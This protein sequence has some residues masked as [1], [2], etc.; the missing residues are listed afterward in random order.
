MY[1][2]IVYIC[3]CNYWCVANSNNPF[4]MHDVKFGE[5]RKNNFFLTWHSILTHCFQTCCHLVPLNHEHV[6]DKTWVTPTWMNLLAHTW[7]CCNVE[8]DSSSSSL[9]E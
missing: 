7:P 9:V 3:F 1:Y 4:Y 6:E 5:S 8:V 2:L